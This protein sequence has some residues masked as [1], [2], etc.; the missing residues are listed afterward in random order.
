[1]GGGGLLAAS[2]ML[3]LLRVDAEA[4]YLTQLLPALLLFSVGLAAT[5]APLTARQEYV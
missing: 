1:M 4:D 3:L 5:V 2:G